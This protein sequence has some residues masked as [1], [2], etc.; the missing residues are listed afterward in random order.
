MWSVS[1]PAFTPVRV[2]SVVGLCFLITLS[3]R[4]RTETMHPG[5]PFWDMPAD[6]HKY[7]YLAEHPLG[8]FHIQPTCWRIG[9]PML[10]KAMPF[11]T[12]RNFD[13]LTIAFL[14]LSGLMVYLWLTAIPLDPGKAL[15]GVLMF[16]SLGGASKLIAGA[17]VSP[18]AASYFFILLAL[19]AIYRGNDVLFAAALALGV[20]TKETV[21]LIGPLY[22]TLRTPTWWDRKRLLRTVLVCA[23]C[24]CVF[25]AVRLL[26][27]AWNDRDDY[28]RSLPFIYTQVSAGMVR[29]DLLTAFRGTIETYRSYTPINLLRLFTWGSLGVHLFLPFFAPR[30]N[31]EPFV[32]WTPYWLPIMLSLLIALNADR[33]VSSFFPVLIILGLNGMAALAAALRLENRHFMVLFVMLLGLLWIKKDVAIAP[34]DLAAAVFLGWL[35]WAVAHWQRGRMA[36][37]P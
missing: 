7:M 21:L 12:W 36:Q 34:F 32:R 26:I 6:H 20:L 10:A 8:S 9:V 16:Y 2:F 35:A 22:Y 15:L 1:A 28:V 27:P 23:P 37:A 3:L 11:S 13:I 25:A 30:R 4:L 29:Y 33:R 17:V 24:I 19:Y 18:D 31:R 5:G 14:T